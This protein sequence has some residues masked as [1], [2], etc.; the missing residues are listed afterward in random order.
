MSTARPDR[1]SWRPPRLPT[2]R[3][4]GHKGSRKICNDRSHCGGGNADAARRPDQQRSGAGGS[5]GAKRPA[6]D[7]GG[8]GGADEKSVLEAAARFSQA[9][10]ELQLLGVWRPSKRRRVAAVQRVFAPMVVHGAL[11]GVETAYEDE[12]E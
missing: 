3:H 1:P 4:K 2:S 5:A 11:E 9:A 10:G 6:A 7:G 12:D 8:G